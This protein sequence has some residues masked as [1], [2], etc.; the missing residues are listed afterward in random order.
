MPLFYAL[1]RHIRFP[2]LH[3]N[4]PIYIYIYAENYIAER[5]SYESP[6]AFLFQNGGEKYAIYPAGGCGE[7]S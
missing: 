6:S 5:F 7:G 1:Y 2:F 3:T 4:C